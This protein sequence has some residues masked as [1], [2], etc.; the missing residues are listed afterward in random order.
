MF[1]PFFVEAQGTSQA[2]GQM[3]LYILTCVSLGAA[4]E[5]IGL[6]HAT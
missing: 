1:I 5:V 4:V 2:T 6:L 3:S